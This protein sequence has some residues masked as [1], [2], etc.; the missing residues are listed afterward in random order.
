MKLTWP[1]ST[2]EVI[3]HYYLFEYFQDD[4]IMVLLKSVVNWILFSLFLFVKKAN[5]ELVLRFKKFMFF[6]CFQVPESKSANRTIDGFNNDAI[7]EAKGVVR[8][9]L[10]GGFVLQKVTS[11]RSYFR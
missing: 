8:M 2:R 4:M 7:P 11:E 1:L 10:V 5:S 3:V 6:I 9:D